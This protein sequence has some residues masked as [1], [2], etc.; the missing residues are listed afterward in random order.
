MVRDANIP[1]LETEFNCKF[2][3]SKVP[4]IV[5]AVNK[6]GWSVS[7]LESVQGIAGDW[8]NGIDGMKQICEE[9]ADLREMFA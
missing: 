2:V 1:R 5:I 9:L 6:D 7:R 4:G 3:Q 8:K